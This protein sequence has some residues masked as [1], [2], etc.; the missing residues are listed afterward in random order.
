[1]PNYAVNTYASSPDPRDYKYLMTG[2]PNGV[3]YPDVVDREGEV[4]EYED[5]L[6][7]PTCVGNGALSDCEGIGKRNGMT[8][9]LSRMFTYRRSQIWAGL[10]PTIEGTTIRG[11]LKSLANDGVPPETLWPYTP[12]SYLDPIPQYVMDAAAAL[13][14]QRYEAIVSPTVQS[15]SKEER[16]DHII[17]AVSNGLWVWI[18]L[19]VSDSIRHFTGPWRNHQ[20]QLLSQGVPDIGGHFLQIVG[21][22]RQARMFKC[23]NSWGRNYG[24]QGISGMPFDIVTEFA[25]E[26]WV[27]RKFAG[28]YTREAPGIR[29]EFINIA[30]IRARIVPPIHLIGQTTKLWIVALNPNDP[31]PQTRWRYKPV[32]NQNAFAPIPTSGPIPHCAEIELTDVVD[33]IYALRDF[34][35]LGEGIKPFEGWK[36]YVGYGDVYDLN[37]MTY[38][39][40]CTVPNFS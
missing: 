20:Y 26:S 1:M 9:D 35:I 27:L 15:L 18:A 40:I 22:D 13:K 25:F 2:P 6:T 5:Q 7:Y 34:D 28:M 8:L 23:L 37:T 33:D 36:V 12:D 39:E 11:A 24:D 31:N 32:L 4:A 30:N 16:I 17:D 3:A 19:A 38:A 29:R 14:A 21:Y 10:P